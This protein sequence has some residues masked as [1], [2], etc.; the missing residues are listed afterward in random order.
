MLTARLHPLAGNGAK[1]IHSAYFVTYGAVFRDASGNMIAEHRDGMWHDNTGVFDSIEFVEPVVIRFAAP[2]VGT[3]DT[4]GP[5]RPLRL[6]HGGLWRT[7]ETSEVIA[8][9][10]QSSLSWNF[11]RKRPH[12][13][14]MTFEPLRLI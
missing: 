3:A 8:E 6:A 1:V 4:C 13:A 2:N 7:R 10:D 9:F 5:L 11:G 12:V 14:V